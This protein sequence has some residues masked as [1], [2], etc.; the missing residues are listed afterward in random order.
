[1]FRRRNSKKR[2]QD[3]SQDEYPAS[4]EKVGNLLNLSNLSL[5]DE[6]WQRIV[7]ALAARGFP[8]KEEDL[9]SGDQ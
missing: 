2:E 6:A 8:I 1:M 7:K 5:D 4:I 9:R 3:D